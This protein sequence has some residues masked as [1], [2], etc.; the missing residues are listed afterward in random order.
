[1]A[2]YLVLGLSGIPWFAGWS[3]LSCFAFFA[4]PTA[5]YLIG[6][7]LASL[8]IGS[9]VDRKIKN[10]FFLPQLRLMLLGVL[11]IYSSGALWLW[12]L[13]KLTLSKIL[14]MAVLPFIPGDLLKAFLATSISASLLPKKSYNG[15]IDR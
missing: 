2:I 6:F 10:R 1:M 14:M 3:S 12:F 15:E 4:N 13:L 7:I 11:I 8:F 9:R 5:G